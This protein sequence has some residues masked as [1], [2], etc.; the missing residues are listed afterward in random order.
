L[1]VDCHAHIAVPL[2][3][4]RLPLR[5]GHVL[6]EGREVP[7]LTPAFDPTCSPPET[8]LAHMDQAG[9]ERTWLLQSP[10][11]G[12][13]NALV[14]DAIRRWPD[15]FSGF[16]LLGPV[17]QPDGPD[18]VERLIQA[19][20]AGLK[21][22]VMSTRRAYGLGFR[23]DGEREWKVWERLD[24]LRSLL[25]I[26]AMDA[27]PDDTVAMRRVIEEFSHLRMVQ[28]H[29]GGPTQPGWEER[30]M[31]I[32]HPRVYG[33][34][35]ALPTHFWGPDEEYPFPKAQDNLRW[36]VE[37]FGADKLMWGTDY[38]PPLRQATYRQ[39]LE[40]IPRH[41]AFLTD[42]QK[43]ALLGGTAES[44]LNSA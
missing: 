6:F 26:D 3:G 30:A 27:P 9:V 2:T 12:N 5:H 11:Y 14:L 36:A 8:L 40:Y 17:D 41:C 37:T 23:F 21:V 35:S 39:L 31:L 7:W 38:P 22:M 10:A 20:M 13:Q 29:L 19:G 25:V 1:I 18:Q 32:R 42:T 34:I 16:A 15:R 43:E 24:Q 4:F 28:C 33:D 44:L